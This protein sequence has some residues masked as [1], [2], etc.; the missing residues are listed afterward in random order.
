[1]PV[2]AV[3]ANILMSFALYIGIVAA[4]Y[5]GT[6]VAAS[7]RGAAVRPGLKTVVAT[8]DQGVNPGG[9]GSS[10]RTSAFGN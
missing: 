1:M 7:I 10:G 4:L 3:T 5:G 2:L 6:D 8:V 9:G